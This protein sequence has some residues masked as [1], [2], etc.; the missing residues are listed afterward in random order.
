MKKL[1]IGLVGEK[2][3]GKE[4]FGKFLKE[5]A[6]DKKILHG[7][8]SDILVETLELWSI[9]KTRENLQDLA[10]CMNR[11]FGKGT[12]SHAMFE[13][14]NKES[15]DI[16]IIDGVRWKSDVELTRK[17]PNS[18]LIYITA[19]LIARYQRLKK[20][21][22]KA[23]EETT[24]FKQFMHEEKKLTETLIPKI[25]SG[26]DFKIINNGSL[27]QFRKKVEKLYSK[28]KLRRRP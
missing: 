19:P 6:K 14:V 3:S 2:G 13:K 7:R 12:L 22:E 20:R 1:V 8:F 15:D 10:I 16:V 24:N 21:Q 17:F 23:Y 4:T 28:I 27:A 18:L 5:V 9:P 26:A 25:G 11:G